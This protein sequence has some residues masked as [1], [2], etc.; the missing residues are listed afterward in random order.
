MTRLRHWLSP[1]YVWR[2]TVHNLPQKLLALAAAI[3]LWLVATADR[4]TNIE[5]SF[6]VT[7]EVRD[8]TGGS[9][10]R[11]VSSLPGT[12]RVT[13][14]GT[15]Q[16]LQALRPDTVEATVDTTNVPEGSFSLPVEVRAPD[17]THM[18]RTT[19]GR[20]EGFVDSQLSRA[21]VVELSVGGPAQNSLP[22]YTLSPARTEVSGPSRLVNSVSRVVTVPVVLQPG[23]QSPA[24]LIALSSDGSAVTGLTLNPGGVT[25]TRIDQGG[26]PLKTV[27]VTL[28]RPPAGLEVVSSSIEPATVRVVAPTAVLATLQSAPAV[29]TYREGSYNLTPALK[30]PSGAQALEQVRVRLTVR[31]R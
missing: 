13:L 28:P 29:L 31:K 30:L 3:A 6:D 12:V 5:Q 20:V 22:R 16:R 2:R 24:N 25:V 14:S 4:R 1:G 11:A 26:L 23:D 8:T 9:S 19:P 18:V 15:R 21:F 17:G 7:L 27:P 10:K